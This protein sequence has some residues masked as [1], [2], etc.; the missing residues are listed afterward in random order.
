MLAPLL[1]TSHSQWLFVT[2]RRRVLVSFVAGFSYGYK[3]YARDDRM[4]SWSEFPDI[5]EPSVHKGVLGFF[6]FFEHGKLS[7]QTP[8]KRGVGSYGSKV[9]LSARQL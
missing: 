6:F 5:K 2:P 4:F 7:I 1:L 8:G 3:I 9:I